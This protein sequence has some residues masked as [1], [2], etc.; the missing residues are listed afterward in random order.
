MKFQ[1]GSPLLPERE[2]ALSIANIPDKKCH[3]LLEESPIA[4]F[5]GHPE[6]VRQIEGK[7]HICGLLQLS[8]NNRRLKANSSVRMLLCTFFLLLPMTSIQ[9]A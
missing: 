1:S 8:S 3:E 2:T 9:Y 4:L 6:G 7:K 5:Q